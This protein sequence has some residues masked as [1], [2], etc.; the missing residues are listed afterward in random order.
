MSLDVKCACGKPSSAVNVEIYKKSNE[1]NKLLDRFVKESKLEKV[2]KINN[3]HYNI[4]E[5]ILS[6]PQR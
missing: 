4:Y 1:H 2:K 3:I 5:K 6:I